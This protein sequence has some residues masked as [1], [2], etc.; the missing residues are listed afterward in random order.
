[1]L[2]RVLFGSH[3]YAKCLVDDILI[4]S[5]SFEEHLVHIKDILNRL[6]QAGLTLDTAKCHV[7]TKSI[8]LFGFQ[9]DQGK[10]TVDDDKVEIIKNPRPAT[11]KKLRQFL[12]LTNCESSH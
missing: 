4:F 7:A 9:I 8:K 1:M 11:K 12:G 3:K 6:R 5:R 2:H 10:V